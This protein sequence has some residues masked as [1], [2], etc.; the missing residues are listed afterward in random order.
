MNYVI[1]ETP[2]IKPARVQAY[3]PPSP[4]PWR[5]QR[6][7]KEEHVWAVTTRSGVQPS[8]ITAEKKDRGKSNTNYGEEQVGQHEKSTKVSQE[9]NSQE[10]TKTILINKHTPLV[11][12]PQRL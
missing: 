8:E 10:L 7:P 2:S 1:I 3:F 9:I 12:F 5:L 6:Q 11:S 4:F